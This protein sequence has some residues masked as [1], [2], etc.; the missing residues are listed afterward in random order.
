MAVD[1]EP[2]DWNQTWHDCAWPREETFLPLKTEK[3][4]AL[5]NNVSKT[6][7]LLKIVVM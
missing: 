7:F 1:L 3:F 4:L 6:N 5:L 2:F